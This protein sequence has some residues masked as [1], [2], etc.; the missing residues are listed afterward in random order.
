M[1]LTYNDACA[2]NRRKPA[3]HS[4]GY[5]MAARGSSGKRG[6]TS[7][8]A[9]HGTGNDRS[10]LPPQRLSATQSQWRS[11]YNDSQLILPH[12]ASVQPMPN[13]ELHFGR[14]RHTACGGVRK[15]SSA[16]GL[17]ATTPLLALGS[18]ACPSNPGP[19]GGAPGHAEAGG[20]RRAW[21]RRGRRCR[22]ARHAA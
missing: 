5:I 18:S 19:V 17:S 11:P 2:D 10:T 8:T 7:H 4:T 9:G 22:A 20:W 16:G 14:P 3:C 13:E 1:H 21:T 12:Q 6:D 15:R